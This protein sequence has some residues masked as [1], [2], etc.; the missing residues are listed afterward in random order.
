MAVPRMFVRSIFSQYPLLL[1]SRFLAKFTHCCLSFIAGRTN[2]VLNLTT[3]IQTCLYL[4]PV[5][6][7]PSG[8]LTQ[9]RA[10]L[11]HI[12]AILLAVSFFQLLHLP[13]FPLYIHIP[14]QQADHQQ[15]TKHLYH[16]LIKNPSTDSNHNR[17]QARFTV[18]QKQ[19]TVVEFLDIKL[20]HQNFPPHLQLVQ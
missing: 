15:S 4:S 14:R 5:I 16:L 13:H 6:G 1:S 11:K 19:G 10:L 8:L 12:F 17:K 20:R 9:T 3:I 18:A 7:A 2:I